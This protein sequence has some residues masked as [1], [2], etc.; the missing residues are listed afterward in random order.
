MRSRQSGN[1]EVRRVL[2]FRPSGALQAEPGK[3]AQVLINDRAV[4]LLWTRAPSDTLTPEERDA[5]T[6]DSLTMAD[7]TFGRYRIWRSQTGA[8]D[9]FTLLREFSIFNRP[10]DEGFLRT[11]YGD[12][13]PDRLHSW[14]PFAQP[15]ADTSA[16]RGFTDPDDIFPSG[17]FRD[18]DFIEDWLAGKQV[19]AGPHDGFK[20]FY[21]VTWSDVFIDFT[22][23]SPRAVYIQRQSL[24]EGMVPE[25]ISPSRPARGESPLL[26]EVAVVPN[27]YIARDDKASF[28]GAPRIQFVH[29]PGRCTISIY[30]IAGDLVRTLE[31]ASTDDSEDWDLIN[32]DGSAVSSGMYLYY[33][34]ASGQ[35]TRG[36]FVL[37]R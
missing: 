33:I 35:E 6:A 15:E 3:V 17:N 21:A 18:P 30:T 22:N 28:P 12:D 31:H 37:A 1:G 2:D 29:L 27:P 14:Y 16:Y 26:A 32:G 10:L 20:Y 13:I 34:L 11:L 19:I 23:G 24:A 4:T 5:I 9:D 8:L 25:P 36:R 7:T